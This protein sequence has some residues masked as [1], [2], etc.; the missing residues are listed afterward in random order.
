MYIHCSK[1][2]PGV[3]VHASDEV[4]QEALAIVADGSSMEG[5]TI[6]EI[7]DHQYEDMFFVEVH[8]RFLEFVRL[9]GARRGCSEIHVLNAHGGNED[10]KWVYEDRSRSFLL[11]RWID[12]HTKQAAAIVLTVCNADGLTVKSRHIPIFIPDSIVGSGFAFLGEYHFTMRLPNGEE[13]DQY[14]IDYHLKQIRLQK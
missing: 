2:F 14:T 6:E 12:R 5:S 4:Y 7:F 13:V 9:H 11:Q 8:A 10:G 1:K 3:V